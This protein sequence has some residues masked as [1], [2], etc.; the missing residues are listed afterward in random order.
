MQLP[1]LKGA[2][3]SLLCLFPPD[4]QLLILEL[5]EIDELGLCVCLSL[6]HAH[7]YRWTLIL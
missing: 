6:I 3:V 2:Q 4:N 1:G 7:V 5:S